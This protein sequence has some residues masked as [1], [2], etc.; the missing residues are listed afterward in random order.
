MSVSMTFPTLQECSGDNSVCRLRITAQNKA[1]NRCLYFLRQIIPS[2]D[3]RNYQ[4]NGK[5]LLASNFCFE[6]QC[7]HAT[8]PAVSL[9]L[10]NAFELK[11]VRPGEGLT[12]GGTPMPV[13]TSYPGV[14]VEEIPSGV[15][16]ITGVATSI[17]T[18]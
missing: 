7:P 17:T 6:L 14:Y 5:K 10:S 15:R 11:L 18:F 12:P 4:P 16:T 3:A 13:A 9:R 2:P 8:S 1:R